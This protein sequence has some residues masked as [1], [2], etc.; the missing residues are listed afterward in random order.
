MARYA[1]LGPLRRSVREG[2]FKILA[3]ALQTD[4]GRRIIADALKGTAPIKDLVMPFSQPPYRN[5]GR[6]PVMEPKYPPIF[7][8]GRFRSGS[9]LLWN[10]FRNIPGCTSF[11]EPLNERRWFD[12]AA[13]GDKV[14]QTHVGVTDYWSEYDGLF[15]ISR[16][17]REEWT[18]HRLHLDDQAWEPE[19]FAYLQAI[20][21]AARGRAVI[22]E[23][24]IDFRLPWLR[25]H[26]PNA[27]FIHVYRHP[28][29]QWCSALID[30]K[31]FPSSG[32]MRQF[33]HCDHFYLLRWARDLSYQ[34]PF[35]D[36][37]AAEHPYDLFY[38]IW[39]LS[40]LFGRVYCD[41]SFS[42]EKLCVQP[43]EELPRLMEASKID[44]YDLHA[45]KSLIHPQES[46]KWTKYADHSWF[47]EREVRC[48]A[49][50]AQYLGDG[51]FSLPSVD[52]KETRV[53]LEASNVYANSERSGDDAESRIHV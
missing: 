13:R 6:A 11:Y 48:E 38:L 40:Y 27:R 5:V 10:I 25:R 35:L 22:Q 28:R 45:L 41:E 4:D 14:D 20:I 34:F 15:H 8:T 17:Y 50:L 24:R 33:T 21:A 36:P 30:P 53:N 18:D 31:N 2:F 37:R 7:I 51:G 32:T 43:D 19:L 9:T 39:K 44:D 49:V 3:Q 29:D 1:W 12:R 23:N 52:E 46:R 47:A 42:L 16:W 26:F